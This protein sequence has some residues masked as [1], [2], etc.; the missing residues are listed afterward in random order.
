M[1]KYMNMNNKNMSRKNGTLK[2]VGLVE[3]IMGALNLSNGLLSMYVLFSQGQAV[4]DEIQKNNNITVT[5]SEMTIS[6][7]VTVVL[8]AA[9]L[10]AGLIAMMFNGIKGKEKLPFVMGIILLVCILAS[11]IINI[12][13]LR[14][15]FS[16][17]F[18]LWVVIH[19]LYLYGAYRNKQNIETENL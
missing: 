1:N 4:L 7:L 15:T 16:L 12:V 3:L 5:M 2:W 11:N 17:S 19:G 14:S 9:M 13:M 6:V 10:A 8:G 18:I